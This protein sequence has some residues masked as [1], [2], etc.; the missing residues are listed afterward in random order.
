M[1]SRIQNEDALRHNGD[2][3]H[4]EKDDC[5]ISQNEQLETTQAMLEHMCQK[6]PTPRLP[7]LKTLTSH[8][9]ELLMAQS[10]QRSM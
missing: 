6:A 4:R 2:I 9:P 1:D 8:D 5:I 7:I 10:L 3:Y